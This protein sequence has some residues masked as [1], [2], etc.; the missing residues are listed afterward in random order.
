MRDV[1]IV[2]ATTHG[3]TGK[4]A[5]H[6]A[7]ALRHLGLRPVVHDV[8]SAAPLAPPDYDLVI[9]GG[10]V[11]SGHHQRELVTWAKHQ[12]AALNAMPSAFFSVCLT[13]AEDTEESRKA[14]R[15]YI[16][17]FEDDTGWRPRRIESVA[18]ALEYREY[19]FPTR[20]LMRLLMQR[21][22][23]PTD[24]SHDYVYTDWAAVERFARD[25]AAM[26]PVGGTDPMRA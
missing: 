13:A 18:G 19:D 24:W 9:A 10:S 11:H 21:G 14:T 20:L 17:E 4:V 16:D 15:E 6:I 25:C 5:A 7:K 2:Y 12:A 23:H 26:E 8:A 22:D 3:H 1:L